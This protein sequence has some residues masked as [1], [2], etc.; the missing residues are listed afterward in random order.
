MAEG[1]AGAEIEV[2]LETLESGVRAVVE[3]FPYAWGSETRGISENEAACLLQETLTA[4]RIR[5]RVLGTLVP[6]YRNG[7]WSV[8]S[9]PCDQEL[10]KSHALGIGRCLDRL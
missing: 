4:M 5:V 9:R 1:Q 3:F 10:A 7:G 6:P 2:T 8:A